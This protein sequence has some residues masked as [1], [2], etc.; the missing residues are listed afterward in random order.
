MVEAL[1]ANAEVMK[2]FTR[3]EIERMLSP[4]SYIGI[5]AASVDNTLARKRP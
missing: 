4:H 3:A 1:C 5:A 2:H